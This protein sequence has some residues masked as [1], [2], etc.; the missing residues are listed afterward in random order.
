M[1]TTDL[2][3]ELIVIGTGGFICL[4]LLVFTLF[5]YDWMPWH[6]MGAPLILVFTLAVIY[7]IGIIQDRFVDHFFQRWD[8]PLRAKLFPSI[9]DYY[10][11]RRYVYS[12][13]Q[14][15]ILSLFEYRRS[16]MRICRGWVVNCLILAILAPIFALTR[17]PLSFGLREGIAI[18]CVILFGVGVR[19]TWVIWYRLVSTDYSR[20]AD[21]YS[22]LKMETDQQT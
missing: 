6:Q 19:A 8:E 20:L 22:F 11:A 18:F 9:A 3:V 4:M 21:T 1:S 12:H 16:R 15:M 7:V 5:G 13:G 14:A 2:F 10:E 17:L